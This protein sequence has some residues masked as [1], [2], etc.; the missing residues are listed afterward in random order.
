[1]AIYSTIAGQQVQAKFNQLF[2]QLT[3]ILH[4]LQ[5]EE[6]KLAAFADVDLETAGI[7]AGDLTFLK[8]AAADGKGIADVYFTGTDTRNP[9]AGY[10]YF[11]SVKQIL[12]P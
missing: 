4:Q 8:S 12:G 5:L 10:I 9:G 6:S 7:S 2:A 1:M 11:N 3:D